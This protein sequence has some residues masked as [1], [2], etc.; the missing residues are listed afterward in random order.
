M[1]AIAEEDGHSVPEIKVLFCLYDN[2]DT[3][4]VAGP[5]E[6]L[7]LAAHEADRESFTPMLHLP[8]H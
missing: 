6:V 5:L 7:G 1:S 4:D 2:F 3:M 8:T